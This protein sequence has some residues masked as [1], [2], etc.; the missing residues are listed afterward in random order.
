[1]QMLCLEQGCAI[2]IG[3]PVSGELWEIS[4]CFPACLFKILTETT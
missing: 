4:M 1:M 3:S 2:P